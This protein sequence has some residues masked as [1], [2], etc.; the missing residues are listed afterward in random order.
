MET[1]ASYMIV[2][3]FTL[4]IVVGALLFVLWAA[5]SSQ[6]DMR[7]Y[8]II[9]TQSVSGL[10]TS[11][12][13]LLEGV[14]VGQV[15]KIRVSPQDP[16]QV[17]VHV[18]VAADAPIRRNS[19]ATLEPQGVTGMVA[20]AVSGGTSDSPMLAEVKGTI[21]RIP[22][23]PSKLQEIMNSVPSIMATLDS[24]LERA[25]QVLDPKNVE[26]AG[27]LLI[28]VAEIAE[29][30]AQNKQSIAKAVDGFGVAGHSFASSGKRLE[31]LMASAQTVVDKDIRDTV[32]SVDQ[33]AAKVGSVAS[34]MEPGMKRFS[35]DS[36][37]ELHH[38]LVE[39]RRLAMALAR[40]SQK[41]ESDPR[42]FLL[43]NPVPEFSAP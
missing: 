15:S 36:V 18:T 12:S 4:L 16:G 40:L 13:V 43:G 24:I 5:K 6:S 19:Q 41:L 2:G 21:P 3:G 7:T 11:S 9:F 26:V 38:L 31:Q 42:R 10:S 28:S 34:A 37:D 8:E 29:T 27:N 30:L 14:K 33:A 23:K 39:A 20:I 17:I 35:R 32:K 22:S 1:R 25:N